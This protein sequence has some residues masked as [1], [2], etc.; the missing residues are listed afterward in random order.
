MGKLFLFFLKSS[1]F[2]KIKQK[3]RQCYTVGSE[4]VLSA[5]YTKI[6][7]K[8]KRCSQKYDNDDIYVEAFL[9]NDDICTLECSLINVK[10]MKCTK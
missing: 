7:Q 2:K 8:G 6:F 5:G 4:Q 10:F 3:R 1:F 9:K